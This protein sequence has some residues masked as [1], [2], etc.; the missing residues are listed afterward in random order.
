MFPIHNIGHTIGFKFRFYT[1]KEST[2]LTPTSLYQLTAKLIQKGIIT[3][4]DI[5]PHVSEIFHHLHFQLSPDDQEAKEAYESYLE[6]MR[7]NWVPDQ[8]AI[9]IPVS[10]SSLLSYEHFIANSKSR[11]N[12][13][14]N[15]ST[16]FYQSSRRT[17]I[18]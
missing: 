5:Y 15:D 8:G 4:D 7:K 18:F 2:Q 10:I 13:N 11:R 1:R 14:G 3:V 6:N 9:T 17:S 12:K 16:N